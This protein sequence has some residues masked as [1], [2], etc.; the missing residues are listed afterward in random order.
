MEEMQDTGMRETE[1][2]MLL[3]SKRRK[4]ERGRTRNNQRDWIVT[5][6]VVSAKWCERDQQPKT[7]NRAEGIGEKAKPRREEKGREAE[8]Q[9]DQRVCV[10][11]SLSLFLCPGWCY[12]Q[13]VCCVCACVRVCVCALAKVRTNL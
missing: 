6:R 4:R 13:R 3:T 8:R 1:V 9:T 7:E 5:E 11:F 2:M 12:C 10:S